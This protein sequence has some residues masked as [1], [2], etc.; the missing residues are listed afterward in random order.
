MAL[1]LT[2]PLYRLYRKRNVFCRYKV[3]EYEKH[4]FFY[5]ALI[6]AEQLGLFLPKSPNG[7][8]QHALKVA[9]LTKEW[10]ENGLLLGNIEL[11]VIM[12][13]VHNSNRLELLDWASGDIDLD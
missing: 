7:L 1:A 5:A 9:T 6:S 2:P 4:P 12:Q 3:T 13:N 8:F 10:W 11:S